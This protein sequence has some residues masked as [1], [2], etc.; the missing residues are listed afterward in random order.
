MFSFGY[1]VMGEVVLSAVPATTSPTVG[2]GQDPN[3]DVRITFT[4]TLQSATNIAGIFDDVSGN[5]QGTY[6]I[7][8]G[9]LSARQYFRAKGD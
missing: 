4:G 7:P 5:P 2:I 3:G 9:S 6:V 1:A 8:G